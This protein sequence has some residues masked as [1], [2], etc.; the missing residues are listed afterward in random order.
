MHQYMQIKKWAK[1]LNRHFFKE[2]IQM[3]KKHTKRCSTSLTIREMQI[4][5][6]M[7]YHLT[8]VRMAAIRKSTNNKCWRGCGEKGTLLHCCWEWKLVK[9]L[10]RTVWKFLKKLEGWCGEGGGSGVQD[11]EH[12]YAHGGFMLMCG[13]TNTIL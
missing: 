11:G 12:V 9:P 1:E 7:K 5:S 8:P 3:A 13:R 4:K 2:D 6:T 10:W